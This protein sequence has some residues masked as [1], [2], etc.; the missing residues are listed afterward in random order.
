MNE[1]VGDAH[2]KGN[3]SKYAELHPRKLAMNKVVWFQ[4]LDW[5]RIQKIL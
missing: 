1:C 3:T 2:Y 5:I 4:K